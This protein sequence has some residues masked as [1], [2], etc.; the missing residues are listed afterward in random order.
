MYAIAFIGIK[1]KKKEKIKKVILFPF[2]N[3]I[4]D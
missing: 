1:K 3:D 4:R 2:N